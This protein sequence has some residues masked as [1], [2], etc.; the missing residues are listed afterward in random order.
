MKAWD[1]AGALALGAM[2]WGCGASPDDPV[3]RAEKERR[4]AA[5]VAKQQRAIALAQCEATL[6]IYPP[7]MQPTRPFRVIGPVE[8]NWGFTA[9]S[10][11]Q[12]MRK[13]A[14]ELGAH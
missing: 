2:L 11:F 5:A 4:I 8:G 14:C 1:V 7:G 9:E 6:E 12:R 3:E 10:R 13:K